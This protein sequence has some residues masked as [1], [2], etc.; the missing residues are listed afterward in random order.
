MECCPK[1][2]HGAV[3]GEEPVILLDDGQGMPVTPG[4]DPAEEA[5]EEARKGVQ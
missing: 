3:D 2:A 5:Q 1:A 4:D